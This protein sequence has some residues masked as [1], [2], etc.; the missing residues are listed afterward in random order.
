[1]GNK[2][3]FFMLDACKNDG[4]ARGFYNEFL[5]AELEPHRKTMEIVGSKMRAEESEN[6][7]SGLGFSSTQ[8]NSVVCRVRGTFNRLL[9][10]TF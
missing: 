10:I 9:K 5:C 3:Y 6:Q 8:R 1:V 4:S 2:H 7:L